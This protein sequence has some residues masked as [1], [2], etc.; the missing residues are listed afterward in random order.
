MQLTMPSAGVYAITPSDLRDE[1]LLLTQTEAA[2][3]SGVSLVQYR[4]KQADAGRRERLAIALR[5]LCH[6]YDVPL[7]INDNVNLAETSLADGVHLGQQDGS[8]QA[9]RKQLGNNAI[10]GST[11]HGQAE[12]AKAAKAA[13]AN[14]VAFG[15]FF[16]SNTKASAPPA[17]PRILRLNHGLPAIAIGGVN[18]GNGA[19]LIAAGADLLAVC[20]AIYGAADITAAT[21]QLTSLFPAAS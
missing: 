9:A 5:K 12:L 11:C 10:I 19:E 20:D 3:T 2:L 7:L 14:Y 13:G 17:T 18:A 21:L 16:T 15:R 4:D 8:L 6:N 1:S